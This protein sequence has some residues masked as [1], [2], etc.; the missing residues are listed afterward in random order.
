M[1]IQCIGNDKCYRANTVRG[2]KG[3]LQFKY[4]SRIGF[5]EEEKSEQRL[6]GITDLGSGTILSHIQ[7]LSNLSSRYLE[8]KNILYLFYR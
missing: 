8:W 7:R 6:R 1:I 4:S 5:T 3:C 2:I